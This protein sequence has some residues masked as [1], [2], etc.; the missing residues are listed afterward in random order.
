MSTGTRDKEN[1]IHTQPKDIGWNVP[2]LVQFSPTEAHWGVRIDESRFI[3]IGKSGSYHFS[4]SM[5]FFIAK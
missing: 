3:L 4:S 5:L 2:F 1:L